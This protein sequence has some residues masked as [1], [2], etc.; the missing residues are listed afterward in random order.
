MKLQ[1]LFSDS[2][3]WTRGTNARDS[4]GMPVPADSN[5]AVCYCLLGG[6]EKCYNPNNNIWAQQN[7]AVIN[8]LYKEIIQTDWYK[9]RE[10]EL[11]NEFASYV[12]AAFNDDRSNSINDIRNLIKKVDV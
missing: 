12:V 5:K 9:D 10:E 6:I 4:E 2:T 8:K 3:K 7:E 11:E 1:S